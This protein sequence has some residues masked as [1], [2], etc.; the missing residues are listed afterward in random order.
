MLGIYVGP[1]SSEIPGDSEKLVVVILLC[2]RDTT[3]YNLNPGL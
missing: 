1:Q 2:N 3:P